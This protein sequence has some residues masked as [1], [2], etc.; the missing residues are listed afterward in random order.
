M[1]DKLM[2]GTSSKVA[3]NCNRGIGARMKD[4]IGDVFSGVN[5]C[6]QQTG[7]PAA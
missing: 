6:K 1:S 7:A 4:I 3:L 2:D 5:S